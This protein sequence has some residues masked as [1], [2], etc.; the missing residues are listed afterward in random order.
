M[1]WSWMS[2]SRR[3]LAR[4]LRHLSRV[5][6][7]MRLQR[8]L[9]PSH[10]HQHEPTH[11]VPYPIAPPNTSALVDWSGSPVTFVGWNA[12]YRGVYELETLGAIAAYL[13][14][15]GTM[16]EVG[17]NEGYHT[18]FAAWRAGPR[19][20]VIAFEPSLVPRANLLSNIARLDWTSRVRVLD[21]AASDRFGEATFYIPDAD[22][23]NQGVAG[24]YS[25]SRVPSRQ[26]SVCT[27]PLDSL[28]LAGPVDLI[29]IDVQDAEHLVLAGGVALLERFRPVVL[30]EV[31]GV[32]SGRS[33]ETLLKCDYVIKR[34]EPTSVAP[35]F[36]LSA[37]DSRPPHNCLAIPRTRL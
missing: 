3:R 1:S 24:F 6:G 36:A 22:A 28:D 19:G 10:L 35:F 9:A 14:T 15:A 8:A 34:L 2:P 21:V 32:H 23:E 20:L 17:A 29:K 33:F 30:F 37:L 26:T 18:I 27:V 31:G 25:N 4:S 16:I 5:R 11:L 12:L 13:P 7:S